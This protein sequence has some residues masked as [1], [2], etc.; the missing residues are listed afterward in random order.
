MSFHNS[1]ER[2]MVVSSTSHAWIH[3]HRLVEAYCRTSG[4]PFN[5]VFEELEQR[6]GFRRADRARWPDLDT[7]RRAAEWLREAR[8]RLL[9]ERRELVRLQREAKRQ[10]RRTRVARRLQAAEA[11]T[12]AHAEGIPRV[13]YWGWR[14][15]REAGS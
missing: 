4:T 12:R 9:D 13:G 14:K 1:Y 8:N 5:V 7:M 10:G 2:I 3:L 15:R 11:R 6:F